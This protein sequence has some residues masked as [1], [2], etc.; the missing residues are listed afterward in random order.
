MWT[1]VLGQSAPLLAAAAVVVGLAAYAFR[2]GGTDVKHQK[3][4]PQKQG[5]CC[6]LPGSS[7][8]SLCSA[9]ASSFH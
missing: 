4:Q 3:Q 6:T 2:G 5:V 9:A 7:L 1:G 8:A